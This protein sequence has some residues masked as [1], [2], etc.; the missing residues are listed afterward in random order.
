MAQNVRDTAFT[1]MFNNEVY[2]AQLYNYLTGIKIN[3][4]QIRSV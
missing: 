1:F 3:P 2:M 4:T